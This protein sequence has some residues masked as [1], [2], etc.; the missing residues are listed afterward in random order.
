MEILRAEATR[1]GCASTA[2]VRRHPNERIRFAGIASAARRAAAAT[3]VVQFV[4]FE[5]EF[6]LL[7]GT[8]APDVYARLGDPIRT[9]GPY[10]A[11]G[12]LEL[13]HGSPVLNVNVVYPFHRRERPYC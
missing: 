12:L 1:A 8:V 6:G 11:E 4:T 5:D 3:G 2:E 10:L 13:Q 7:E 9:P